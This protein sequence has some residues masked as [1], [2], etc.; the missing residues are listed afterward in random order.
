MAVRDAS[1][2]LPVTILLQGQP[3]SLTADHKHETFSFATETLITCFT[4]RV[5]VSVT[6]YIRN[7]DVL[8]SNLGRNIDHPD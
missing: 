1:F 5:R 3:P 8:G 4:E 6:R 7:R 2:T